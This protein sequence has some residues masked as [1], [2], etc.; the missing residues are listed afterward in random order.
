MKKILVEEEGLLVPF[1]LYHVEGFIFFSISIYLIG[2]I[3]THR[4]ISVFIGLL[5]LVTS[6]V[7]ILREFKH[8]FLSLCFAIQFIARNLNV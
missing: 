3:N 6:K 4:S 2:P 7:C 1:S 8:R 5:A